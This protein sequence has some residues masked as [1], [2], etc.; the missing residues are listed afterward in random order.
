M[1]VLRLWVQVPQ[2]RDFRQHLTK[3]H[4]IVSRTELWNFSAYA[5]RACNCKQLCTYY[6][7][8][9]VLGLHW[10]NVGQF[11]CTR[12]INLQ[13]KDKINFFPIG[14]KQ[15]SSK[16]FLLYRLVECCF[17][18][19]VKLVYVFHLDNKIRCSVS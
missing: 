19:R 17:Q 14:A 8:E 15:A 18:V 6:V 13:K 10:Q 9:L 12:S 2:N 1:S 3:S 11:L 7:I 5:G 4:N 16:R